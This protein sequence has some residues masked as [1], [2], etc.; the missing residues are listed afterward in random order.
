VLDHPGGEISAEKDKT[1]FFDLDS[2][3]KNDRRS[4]N[5]GLHG[6]DK[7]GSVSSLKLHP[8]GEQSGGRSRKAVDDP[9]DKE[10]EKRRKKRL[11]ALKKGLGKQEAV[12]YESETIELYRM[13]STEF[14]Y[15]AIRL[16]SPLFTIK[17]YKDS[18]Y[19]GEVHSKTFK[20]HGKGVVVYDTGRVY[21][22]CWHKDKRHGSG[23]E[24]FANGNSYQGNYEQGKPHGKGLYKWRNGENYTGEFNMAAKEGQ[25]LW[26]G[27]KGDSYLGSWQNNKA[28][29]YGVHTWVLGDRYE[30]EWKECLRHGKGTDFFA[31]EDVYVG[32]YAYGQPE[33]KGQYKWKNGDNYAGGF[34]KGLKHGKGKWK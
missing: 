29:G 33:G 21:E 5:F 3:H 19:R 4:P 14:D 28:H 16:K 30:G 18:I 9:V 15:E 25:G 20:R 22:G 1:A 23:Y 2:P 6:K 24:L 26:K 31:N 12:D 34:K 8:N 32:E 17:Q 10:L 13:I 11:Q 7:Q 27:F